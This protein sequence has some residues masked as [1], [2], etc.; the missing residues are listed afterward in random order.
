MSSDTHIDS[1]LS[2]DNTTTSANIQVKKDS[3]RKTSTD[4]RS[5]GMEKRIENENSDFIELEGEVP[6]VFQALESLALPIYD[7]QSNSRKLSKSLYRKSSN[8]SRKEQS[9]HN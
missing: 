5:T 9:T 3:N 2:H 8:K 1:T 6:N 7:A 4:K